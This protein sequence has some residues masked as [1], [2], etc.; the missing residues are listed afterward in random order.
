MYESRDHAFVVCAY[1]ENPFLESTVR[2]LLEQT[3]PCEVVISTSTPNEHIES[4]GKALGVKVIVNP[5]PHLAGDDWNYGYDSVEAPLVTIAHQDDYY[6]PRFLEIVLE[7]LNAYPPN[8][9]SLTFTDYFEM[10][11]GQRVDSNV[12]LNVKRIMNAPFRVRSLNGVPFVKKRVLAFG[13]S[14][15][16]PAVTLVKPVAG[17]SVFNTTYKNSCDYKTWVDLAFSKGRF[18]YIPQKLVGH[19]IYAESATSLNLAEDI[20]KAEDAEIL[21]TLWPRPVA[22]LVNSIYA[23]SEKSNNL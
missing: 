11:D 19:R 12:L 2:T 21:S 10:R 6:D 14:I 3:V 23:L 5:R 1:K 8:E 22:R 20:R 4:V 13:S 15:C 9:V 16:C 7:T 18:V 17:P